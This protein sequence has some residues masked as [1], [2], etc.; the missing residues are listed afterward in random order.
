MMVICFNYS[1]KWR[2]MYNPS[3]CA[4]IVFNEPKHFIANRSWRFGDG[5]VRESVDYTHLKSVC[6]KFM[7]SPV[8]SCHK[9]KS[10]ILGL[11]SVG[12]HE[13]GL[14]PSL[15]FTSL[16]FFQKHSIAANYGQKFNGQK[17]TR[18]SQ[19]R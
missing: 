6:N 14:R 16:L 8:N 7:N 9:L 15:N 18:R 2:Y 13:N 10:T 19:F 5:V 4:V 17:L 11:L 3:E 12:V 1:V